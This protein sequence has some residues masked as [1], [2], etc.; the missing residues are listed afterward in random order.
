MLLSACDQPPAPVSPPRPALVIQAG[1]HIADHQAMI[2]VGEVKSRYTSNIGFRIAGKITQ[3]Y[4]DVGA[5]VK[6]GQVL[7]SMDANDANLSA[8]AASADVRAAE[9]NNA[10]ALAELQRQRQLYEKKFISKSALDLREAEYKTATA[11]LQQVK[12]Q[13]AVSGNQSRY[14]RLVAD[15]AGVV[16]M[17]AAEPG[18]VV[19]AGQTVA[20][21]VDNQQIEVLVAVPESR[22]AQ[23]KLGQ[24]VWIK[25]WADQTK[26]YTGK[27]REMAPAADSATRAFDVRVTVDQPDAA[28]RLGM[29][30]GVV[31]SQASAQHMLIPSTAVTQINGVQSVW[32]ISKD[33]IAMPRAVSIGQFTEA[34]IEILSGLQAGE[35]VAVAG[36]HTLINGQR[37]KPQ[38]VNSSLASS[39]VASPAM[40]NSVLEGQP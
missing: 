7:A 26:R 17:I 28:L 10:L 33:G 39:D 9:A 5:Q 2:L 35:L 20:Q 6:A 36:V 24:P 12:S 32:V 25:S 3:R 4:V 34:G 11:R 8:Q 23:V 13:A 22:M 37:V 30:A 16:A 1:Q 14:T 29:T 21:I 27:V 18:Q 19:E 38:L 31:F 40:A 15:R